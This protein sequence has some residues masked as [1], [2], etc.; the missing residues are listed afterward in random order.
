MGSMCLN[1]PT[2]LTLK[3]LDLVHYPGGKG[4]MGLM[5]NVSSVMELVDRSTGE[6]MPVVASLNEPVYYRNGQWIFFQAGYD[7][8]GAWSLIG[9]GNRPGVMVMITGCVLIVI[10]LLYAFYVKPIIIRKMKANAL[11]RAKAGAKG[12]QAKGGKK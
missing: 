8:Q 7:P 12:K 1:L 9:V 2:P 3:K 11:A 10:G 4:E 5:R 6:R